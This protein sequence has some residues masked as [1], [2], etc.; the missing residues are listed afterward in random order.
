MLDEQRI[1]LDFRAK[2]PLYIQL[3]EQLRLQIESGQ[4]QAEEQLPP[5]RILAQKL[6]VNFNTVARAYRI[7]DMEGWI[8][9]QQGRGTYLTAQS[10]ASPAALNLPPPPPLISVLP[11]QEERIEQILNA[12]TQQGIEPEDLLA[13][14]QARYS[15][16]DLQAE[17]QRP[18]PQDLP[19]PSPH[20]IPRP[21]RTPHRKWDHRPVNAAQRGR[22][23]EPGAE[24]TR[25]IAE[26]RESKQPGHSVRKTNRIVHKK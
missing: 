3:I 2:T 16:Q 26:S 19:T 7:L 8:S 14:L 13:Y 25:T 5:V 10:W 12:A 4:F 17:T 23:A 15:E 1:K 11:N 18:L 22:P 9:T 6:R 21:K 24:Q 20:R